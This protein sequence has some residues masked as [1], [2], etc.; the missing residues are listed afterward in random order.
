MRA[1]HD[2]LFQLCVYHVV[3]DVDVNECV[4]DKN[5]DRL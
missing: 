1:I 4:N 2:G 5:C 3:D